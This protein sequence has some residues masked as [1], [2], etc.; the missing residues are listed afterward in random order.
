MDTVA[1]SKV[2]RTIRSDGEPTS[3]IGDSKEVQ[4]L[5]LDG[6]KGLKFYCQSLIS[7]GLRTCL[8]CFERMA[9]GSWI[10]VT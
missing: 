4:Y 10:I 1:I 8:G 2:V 7:E 5:E 3:N 9:S 6:S